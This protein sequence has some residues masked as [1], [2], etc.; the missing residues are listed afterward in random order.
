MKLPRRQFLYLYRR[1]EYI[2]T[3][4]SQRTP[5]LRLYSLYTVSIGTT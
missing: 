1:Q 2:V 3:A 5:G 4:V